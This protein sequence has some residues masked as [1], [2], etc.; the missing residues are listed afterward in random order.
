M[1]TQHSQHAQRTAHTAQ[2]SFSSHLH[3]HV[4]RQQPVEHDVDLAVGLLLGGRQQED[5]VIRCRLVERL[6]HV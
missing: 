1:H 3:L 4:R 5:S 2:H 6:S